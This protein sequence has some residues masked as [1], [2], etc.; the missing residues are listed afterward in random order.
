[1]DDTAINAI[2]EGAAEVRRTNIS[3]VYIEQA[4]SAAIIELLAII[5]RAVA[6]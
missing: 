6:T 1:M 5:A 3:D 4:Q 2:V